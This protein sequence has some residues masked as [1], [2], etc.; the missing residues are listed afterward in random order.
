MSLESAEPGVSVLA[1]RTLRV[2]GVVAIVYA[3]TIA[4]HGG[5]FWPFS[6]YSMFA[7]AGR[8][9]QRALVRVLDEATAGSAL[10]DAYAPEA[11]PGTPLALAPLGIPQNDL[12][13]LLQRAEVWGDTEREALARLFGTAPCRAP[14][15]VLRVSGAIEAEGVRQRAVPVAVLRCEGGRV[16]VQ[17][18]RL[19]SV[20]AS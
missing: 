14:L 18:Q 16:Q 12:S 4:T 2:L 6:S 10:A 5:E 20:E 13:S 1:R 9:W 17:P 15:L 3:A 19:A 11:L 8:P 7:R